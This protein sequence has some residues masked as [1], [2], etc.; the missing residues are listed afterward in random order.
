MLLRLAGWGRG[1]K[2]KLLQAAKPLTP[3]VPGP[4]ADFIFFG[5]QRKMA[6]QKVRPTALQHF[7][8]TS[9][10][11]MYVFTPEKLLSLVGQNFCLASP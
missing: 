1:A 4:T 9:T 3:S 6:S 10:Y 7:F 2:G 11:H 8:K 5:P